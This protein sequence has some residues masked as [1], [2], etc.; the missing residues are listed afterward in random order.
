MKTDMLDNMTTVQ[1]ARRSRR[2]WWFIRRTLGWVVLSAG[3]LAGVLFGLGMV[4][5]WQLVVLEYRFGNPMLGL[6]VVP[7]TVLVGAWLALPVTN[8]ARQAARLA[9]RLGLATL[10][11]IGLAG[12]GLF[13]AHFT[14][15]PEPVERRGDLTL[16]LVTDRGQPPATYLRIWHGSGLTAREV[17]DVGRVCG[18]VSVQF[19]AA[20][21]VMLDT[22]YGDWVVE[23]DPVTGEPR[24][25]LGS[26]CGDP[27]RSVG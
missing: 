19:L 10:C 9:A 3:V 1:N 7:L 2:A 18:S 11:L 6:L 13:G 25:V 16:V 15:T 4:N 26:R 14:F 17:G 12:W 21:R 20:D 22:A 5:P 27:P 24:Q 23:L 8:E